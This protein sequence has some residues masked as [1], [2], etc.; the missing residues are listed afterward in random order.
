MPDSLDEAKAAF[1]A[2]YERWQRG[3]ILKRGRAHLR[4]LLSTWLVVITARAMQA[5]ERKAKRSPLFRL[6]THYRV[7]HPVNCALAPYDKEPT[8][9]PLQG[10][11]CP[12]HRQSQDDEYD[13]RKSFIHSPKNKWRGPK[14]RSRPEGT[15]GG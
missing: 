1:K 8:T 3:A 11:V 10:E 2:D 13:Q 7:R 12:H 4:Q 9:S 5:N 15:E 6:L 14:G